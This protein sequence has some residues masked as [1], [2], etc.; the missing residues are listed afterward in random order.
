MR[1]RSFGIFRLHSSLLCSFD[2]CQQVVPNR[3]RFSPSHPFPISHTVASPPPF[4][5]LC[6]AQCFRM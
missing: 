6:A 3:E 2:R 5:S 1:H 4:L